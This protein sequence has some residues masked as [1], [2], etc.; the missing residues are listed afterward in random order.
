[1]KPPITLLRPW[2]M[3]LRRWESAELRSAVS[4][5]RGMKRHFGPHFPKPGTL[6]EGRAERWMCNCHRRKK[7][8]R[9]GR[10]KEKVMGRDDDWRTYGDLFKTGSQPKRGDEA[11]SKGPGRKQKRYLSVSAYLNKAGITFLNI[12]A[13]WLKIRGIFNHAVFFYF[14]GKTLFLNL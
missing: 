10:R 12:E 7:S 13:A 9:A 4:W 3:S 2:G 5:Q 1:M 11:G 8:G 14:P 6:P